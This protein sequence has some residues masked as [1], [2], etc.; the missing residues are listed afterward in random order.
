VWLLAAAALRLP[1]K[2]VSR[3]SRPLRPRSASSARPCAG[4]RARTGRV[5]GGRPGAGREG[6]GPLCGEM[7]ALP[8]CFRRAP[9]TCGRYASPLGTRSVAS[10]PRGTDRGRTRRRRR[11]GA[12][13]PRRGSVLQDTHGA[14]GRGVSVLSINRRSKAYPGLLRELT[15]APS[16]LYLRKGAPE[17]LS[18]PAVA[19]VGA[20]P[21][22]D[23]GPG[24]LAGPSSHA[25]SSPQTSWP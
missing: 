15:D 5:V 14:G 18:R 11:G 25:K 6:G 4:V 2:G 19:I 23:G 8:A 9:R 17:L 16:H 10:P 1:G 24:G 22:S 12:G 3:T 7:S 20:R 21:V 13:P